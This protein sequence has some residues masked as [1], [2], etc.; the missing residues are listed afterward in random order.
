M[1]TSRI[2]RTLLS[3]VLALCM[4][5]TYIVIPANA[6]EADTFNYVSLGASNTN[7]YGMR[8]YI[9]EEELAL[10]LS[11]QVDKNDVNVYGYER[12]PEGAY[13]DLIRDH[14]SE[15]YDNVTVHQLGISSMRV[16]ELRILLDDTYMGDDYSSWRFTGSDGWFRSAE[17]GGIDALR[18]AYKE[19]ITNADLVTVDIGWNNFG[20]YVCNQLVDY[21]SN[22]KFKWTTDINTIFDTDEEKAAAA[23]A[24]A[25][26]GSYIV[27]YVGE[28]EMATALTDIFAYSILGYIHNFDIVMEKIYELNPD[29][30]VVVLGIQNLLH[31]VN[32]DIGENTLPLGDIFGNFVNMANYYASACSPYQTKYKYVKAGINEHVTIFM[33]YMKDYDG[34]AENLDQNVKDC[35]DYYDDNLFIQ[36]RVDY[37]AA[38]MVKSNFGTYLPQLGYDDPQ[39]FVA[40]GKQGKL[41]S[42]QEIFDLMYWPALNAAYDTLA[43]LVKEIANYE[44]VDGNGLLSGGLDIGA[45]EENLMKA[46]EAEV[47]ENALLATQGQPYTVDLEKIL[48]DSNTKV[49]AAMYIRY[50]MGNSFFA[51]PNATGHEEVKDAVIGVIDNPETEKDQALSDYL[52][53][54]VKQIHKLLCAASGHRYDIVVT[55]PT[56]EEQGYT[57]YTCTSCG[58]TKVD[59]YVDALGHTEAVDAAVEPD[60]ENTGLTEGKH[61]SVCDKVLVAQEVIDALGHTEVVDAAVEPDCTNTGLTEGKHC[62]VCDKV[63]V[64]Q[65]VVDAK[66]HTPGDDADCTTAQVCTVCDAELKPMLGHDYKAVVTPVTCTEN[67]Y[68]TYTCT[69]CGDSYIDDVVPHVGHKTVVDEAVDPDCENTGLTQGMHCSECG[70]VLVAQEVVAA[71][72]HKHVGVVTD[73]TC[74]DKGYTTYTCTVCDDT[75]VDD[76]VDA[77]GHTEVVDVAVAPDCENTGLTEGKHCSVCEKVLVAQEVVDA[78]GHTEVIDAAVAAD[79]ENTGLTEG[80]HCS[81]CDK[82]LVAQVVVDALGHTEVIDAAVAPD[83]ENTGLTEGKHC[84]VCDK[85]LVAQV[86]VDALGHTEVIDAAVAPDCENTGLTEGKHCSVCDK[87]L[88]AQ[89]VVDALGHTEVIDA[90]VAPDCENTG[91]TEGKHC[92]VC[93]KVLVAQEV[94]DALGH[95]EVVDKGYEATYEKEGLT[96]GSHCSVCDKVLVPQEIIPMLIK[97]G[98]VDGDGNISVLDATLVQRHVAQIS[99]ISNERFVVA[100]VDKDNNISV[101]D[102]TIIQRFVAQIISKF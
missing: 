47:Q 86:V 67:G 35:F 27:N 93:D 61:C 69:R 92:S 43:V 1:K 30:T 24:K 31:G 14:Y 62:S 90:A 63:L 7:G 10:L 6:E 80:K 44:S 25:I 48:P 100:D 101:L 17:P 87:V 64:A 83:C 3:L 29:A 2:L 19:N 85:V 58:D 89:E 66:G 78:L 79:C 71:L 96:D 59:D 57:T 84:S 12:T 40:D 77:L 5:L 98:D 11:G 36:T 88:V 33:D 82:V 37:M 46:L 49:V 21:L 99:A 76:Y 23:Q 20:V 8:G 50:Y 73:P 60:C 55:A 16:E 42:M 32:V 70:E 65:E 74:E 41:G 102:A 13:P 9:T 28:G 72:G 97:I 54:S 18:V 68:T 38:E 45:I 51:H 39:A 22:G 56:C 4:M 95:T 94:V 81:V 26:I 91:L 15:I 52:I 34:D 53:E 75:Y